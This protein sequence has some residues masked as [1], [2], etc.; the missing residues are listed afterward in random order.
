MA[1]RSYVIP[2]EA[3][4]ALAR[5]ATYKG[6]RVILT[7]QLGPDVFPHVKATLERL[8]AVYVM[9]ASAFEFEHDQDARTIVTDALATG[10]VMSVK[11]SHGFVSTPADLAAHLVNTYGEISAA[12]GQVL[13]VLEP[14][15]GD[16]HLAREI[17]AHLPQAHLTCIEPAPERAAALRRLDGAPACEYM[18]PEWVAEQLVLL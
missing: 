13:R 2:K 15:A 7:E 4:E 16:G 3:H 11:Q 10:R 18:A 8:G 1:A 6:P 12:P 17:R 5:A 9:R 14:S